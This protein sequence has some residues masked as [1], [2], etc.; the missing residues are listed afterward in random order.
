MLVSGLEPGHLYS[1][2][3]TANTNKFIGAQS[4]QKQVLLPPSGLLISRLHSVIVAHSPSTNTSYGR[5]YRSTSTSMYHIRHSVPALVFVC[6]ARCPARTDSGR[7]PAARA[8]RRVRPQR[9]VAATRPDARRAPRL[10]AGLQGSRAQR[11]LRRGHAIQ[12]QHR[13][14][15]L[16][17]QL[18][19][20]LRG[21]L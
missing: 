19:P 13:A 5:T 8:E 1:V 20:H 14:Q 21:H 15:L 12:D 18:P 17:H 10:H 9:H 16:A 4:Q 7:A 6:S 2:G 11:R 3:V